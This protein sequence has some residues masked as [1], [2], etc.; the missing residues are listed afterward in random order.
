VAAMSTVVKAIAMQR[1]STSKLAATFA[2][3]YKNRTAVAVPEMIL[4]SLDKRRC[5]LRET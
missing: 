5:G 2:R 1:S 3:I 4:A